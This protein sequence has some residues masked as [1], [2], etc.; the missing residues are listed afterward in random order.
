MATPLDLEEQEQLDQI[1][2]FWKT[3]GNLIS[4]VLIVILGS[5]AAWNGYQYWERSQATKAAALFDEVERAVTSGDIARVERSLADMKDKFGAT[6]FAQQAALLAAK[7]LQEKGKADA[8]REALSWV[9]NGASDKAYRDIARLRLAALHLDAKAFD[10]ALKLLGLEFT[11]AMT[12]LASD[13]RADVLQ[14]KGQSTEA[15]A[16]YQQAWQKLADNPDYRRLVQA[17]LNAL[18]VDPEKSAGSETTK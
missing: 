2:H 1:K 6:Q 3:Y 9:A 5:Y 7:T 10:E 4:W 18:G 16:A 8:A 17:K 11:P 13:L 14:A 12:G 15:I